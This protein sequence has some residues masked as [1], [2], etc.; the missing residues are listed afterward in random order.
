MSDRC[1]VPG[2]GVAGMSMGGCL[3][4]SSVYAT[5]WASA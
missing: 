3:V 5:G 4:W 2:P 1:V